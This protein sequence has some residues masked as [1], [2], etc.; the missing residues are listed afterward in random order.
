M[1]MYFDHLLVFAG[2]V[3]GSKS[4]FTKEVET[5]AITI[6]MKNAKDFRILSLVWY[7]YF[8]SDRAIQNRAIKKETKILSGYF[9]PK[10][11]PPPLILRKTSLLILK[12]KF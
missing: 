1:M 5:C 7:L 10:K 11:Q 2:V 9:C 3:L 8:Y 4:F 6:A 12:P